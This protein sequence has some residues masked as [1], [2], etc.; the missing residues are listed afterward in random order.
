MDLPVRLESVLFMNRLSFGFK[1]YLTSVA[2]LSD[3]T[4]NL[5]FKDMQ[6]TDDTFDRARLGLSGINS[7]SDLF[8]PLKSAGARAYVAINTLGG[9]IRMIQCI[10]V[11][12]IEYKPNVFMDYPMEELW[13][14]EGLVTVKELALKIPAYSELLVLLFEGDKQWAAAEEC[15]LENLKMTILTR[16]ILK[17]TLCPQTS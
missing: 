3:Q 6:F 15:L 1:G 7:M 5:L 4:V 14:L 12:P 13:S 16:S 9:S 2:V 17:K 8:D 11:T 10:N